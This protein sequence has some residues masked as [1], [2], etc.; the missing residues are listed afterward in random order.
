MTAL[1]LGPSG[2]GKSAYAE[3]AATRLSSAG[4]AYYIATMVPC[5]EEG[6][7]RVERH[8]EQRKGMGFLAVEKPANVSDVAMPA[9]AVALLEDVPN[10]L[11]NAMFGGGRDW[12]GVF[13]DITALCEKCRAAVLVS[14]EGLAGQPGHDEETR[15]YID[16]LNQL[17]GR[18]FDFADVAI[19]MRDGTPVFVKG[20]ADAL[21]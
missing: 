20:D 19:A 11:G 12:S 21:D 4:A 3:A 5:G 18:L 1:V 10:L 15:G 17:N 14:I 8:R 7:A 2:S 9:G 6:R 16:A 13:A